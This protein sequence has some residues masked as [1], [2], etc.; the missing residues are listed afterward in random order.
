MSIVQTFLSFISLAYSLIY[1]IS[2]YTR[3]S[4]ISSCVTTKWIYSFCMAAYSFR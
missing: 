4:A 2:S 1:L 3:V